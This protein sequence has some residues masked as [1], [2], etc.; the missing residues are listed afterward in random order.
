M[1]IKS[2]T[3]S[4]G[5]F[6]SK[7]SPTIL[8]G[9]S[10]AGMIGTTIMGIRATPKALQI[11][12]D[13]TFRKR[14]DGEVTI[15]GKTKMVPPVNEIIKDFTKKEVIKLTW[16]CYVPTVLMGGATIACIVGANSINLRRNAALV[17]LYSI[18][19]TALKEYQ[20]KVVE[21]VGKTKEQKI[22]DDVKQDK[23]NKNPV[24]KNEVIITGSGETLCYDVMS[25]RYFKSDAD[26]IRAALN[27]LSRDLMSDMFISLSQVYQELGLEGTKL[28]DLVGWHLDQVGSDLIKPYFSSHLTDD[29]RPCLSLDFE[30]EP[31]YVTRDY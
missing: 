15:D 27:K 8:T 3:K 25:G 5:S 4:I 16:K 2:L 10:V 14:R 28:G 30:T 11:L 12:Q 17:S 6:T 23:I 20:A 7:N 13:E 21:V 18:S 9:I 31:K 19:E 24:S 1:D 29:G 22:S 26:K